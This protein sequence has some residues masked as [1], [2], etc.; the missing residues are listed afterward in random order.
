MSAYYRMPTHPLFLPN[1]PKR[2]NERQAD[3]AS[4]L[5]ECAP[6]MAARSGPSKTKP[7]GGE[8]T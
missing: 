4:L 3:V 7:G 6:L 8:R 5:G 2:M 1:S